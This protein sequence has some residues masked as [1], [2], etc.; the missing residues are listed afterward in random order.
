[1][2]EGRSDYN[3][4]RASRV[5]K[6]VGLL[7]LAAAGVYPFDHDLSVWMGHL[8]SSMGGDLKRELVVWG[9]YGQATWLIVVAIGFVLLVPWRWRR[10]LDLLAA[11]GLTWVL[12]FGIKIAAGRPRPKFD[13]PWVILGPLGQYPVNAEAGVRH[14][15]EVWAPISSDIWSMPSSHTAFA[16]MLSVFIAAMA[17]RLRVLA[18]V[19]AAIVALSRVMLGAHYPS[20]VLVG[21]AVGLACASLVVERGLGVRGLDW[22]WKR[23][24]D[25]DAKPAWPEV[26]KAEGSQTSHGE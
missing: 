25:R 9:Q 13:D 4:A 5:W 1:M 10:V 12:A 18:V 6:R 22:F 8:G 11:A 16:V 14:A 15:W 3:P 21:A 17:P 26:V 7:L 19:L 23:F 2:M 20:D 24:V